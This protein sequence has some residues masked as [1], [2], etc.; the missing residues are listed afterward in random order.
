MKPM[1]VRQMK[2][3][4][5]EHADTRAALHTLRGVLHDAIEAEHSPELAARCN[6]ACDALRALGPSALADLLALVVTR[7]GLISEARFTIETS[8]LIWMQQAV[9]VLDGVTMQTAAG[10]NVF[11]SAFRDL[12][13]HMTMLEFDRTP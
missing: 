13:I 12:D 10:L 4:F 1:H 3:S 8:W 11:R 7:E 9:D 6:S 5:P 2:F